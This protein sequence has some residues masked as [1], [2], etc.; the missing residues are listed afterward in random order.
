MDG[1]AWWAAV[2]GVTKSRTRL[3]RLSSSSSREDRVQ[4]ASIPG[5]ASPQGWETFYTG[6]LEPACTSF[7]K[8]HYVY[9]FPAYR[10]LH[11]DSLKW[12][13]QEHF[14]LWQSANYKSWLL[15]AQQ[16]AVIYYHSIVITLKQWLSFQG[17]S[18]VIQ[19]ERGFY[20]LFKSSLNSNT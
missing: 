7:V 12:A 16:S 19:V 8:T 11:V 6:F 20:Q 13:V 1:G 2:H 4:N 17:S 3:K 5:F 14:I 15:H 9:H 10:W 18:V